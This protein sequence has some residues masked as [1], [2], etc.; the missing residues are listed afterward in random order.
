M[1]QAVIRLSCRTLSLE[2]NNLSKRKLDQQ[3]KNEKFENMK[4]NLIAMKDDMNR[5][6]HD[7]SEC[8]GVIVTHHERLMKMENSHIPSNV[9][10]K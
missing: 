10:G 3:A 5:L 6:N 9:K 7:I 2:I 8:K 1:F 4:R